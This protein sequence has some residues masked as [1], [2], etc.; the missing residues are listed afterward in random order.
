MI[1]WDENGFICVC[2][3]IYISNK[4][5]TFNILMHIVYHNLPVLCC[6]VLFCISQTILTQHGELQHN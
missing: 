6:N 5:E 4:K 1:G 3:Y 2:T